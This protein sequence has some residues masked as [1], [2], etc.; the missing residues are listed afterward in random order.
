MVV[1]IRLFFVLGIFSVRISEVLVENMSQRFFVTIKTGA[2]ALVSMSLLAGC[3]GTSTYGT[4]KSQE[5]QLFED[6]TSIASLGSGKKKKKI[7]YISRPKLV[8]P[9]IHAGLPTPAESIE[10]QSGYYPVDP[11][12]KRQ[13][14]LNLIAESERTGK[15]LPDEVIASRKASILR[16]TGKFANPDERDRAALYQ[17]T[18]NKQELRKEFLRRKALASAT[19]GAAPR[20]WLTEPPKEYRTPADSAEVGKI[21]EKETDPR[22]T[23]KKKKSLF[24]WLKGD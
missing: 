23:N 2:F 21:G 17:S 18:E 12:T 3:S 22:A 1:N 7:N 9:P 5:A 13:R 6:I 15:A 19:K 8:K 24:G 20:K 10:T 14:L 11:E 16:P 4:G